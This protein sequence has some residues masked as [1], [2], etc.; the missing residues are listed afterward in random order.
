M[1]SSHSRRDVA[2]TAAPAPSRRV[3]TRGEAGAVSVPSRQPRHL[4][5]LLPSR[6]VLYAIAAIGLAVVMLLI[7]GAVGD[8]TVP[9]ILRFGGQNGRT[10]LG[11][12]VG[13]LLTVIA[14]VFWVRMLAVQMISDEF[15][16]RVLRHFLADRAQQET[17]GFIIATLVY[18][19]VVLQAI[20]DENAGMDSVPNLSLSL[21]A[22]LAVAVAAV[23]VAAVR[24]GA[25]STQIGR[26]VRWLADD[27]VEKIRARHPER[28]ETGE[29]EA[30]TRPLPAMPEGEPRM[31]RAARTGWVRE[32]DE[33]T[34]LAALGPHGVM[35]LDVRS[36]AF[37]IEGIPVARV[38]DDDADTDTDDAIREAI[39]LD[40][41]PSTY[42]DISFGIR[43]LVDIA[44]REL[45]PS[46][47]DSTTVQ[48]VIVH[49]GYV[50]RELVLR[51]LPP[52]VRT[53]ED[54]RTLLR[55]R[56]L[57]MESYIDL[58]LERIRIVDS[59]SPDVAKTLLETVG[60]LVEE[61]HTAGLPERADHFSHHAR[62]IVEKIESQPLLE[63]D[64]QSV[65]RHAE[66][67]LGLTLES[68]SA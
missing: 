54:G 65:R 9:G 11:A 39:R 5:D 40:L 14:L 35:R 43:L 44:E 20:P 8:Q 59:S 55:F 29:E 7:D 10:M 23:V 32:V 33:D 42:E 25:R 58:A 22:V 26:L 2:S 64:K 46:V 16:S 1:R 52:T 31:V 19:L 38:W 68:Q 4:T 12:L 56:E 41:E 36:G 61:C 53:G 15:P 51:D 30:I 27:T 28:P 18:C 48:G 63:A 67:S 50:L 6:P 3:H 21:A 13:A 34:L 17:M 45:S 66:A 57:S 62:L 49:L 60:M 47:G 24:S 37:V